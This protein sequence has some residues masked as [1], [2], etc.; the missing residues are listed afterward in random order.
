VPHDDR[1]VIHDSPGAVFRPAKGVTF[2]WQRFSVTTIKSHDKLITLKRCLDHD[3]SKE[4]RNVPVMGMQPARNET[5]RSVQLSREWRMSRT[6]DADTSL[7]EYHR[8]G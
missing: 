6:L 2:F 8:T 4:G 7:V 5:S 3:S 1:C